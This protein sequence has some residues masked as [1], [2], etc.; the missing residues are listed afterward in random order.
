MGVPTH[1]SK[2]GQKIRKGG[3][4]LC[5]TCSLFSQKHKGIYVLILLESVIGESSFS[6]SNSR[7]KLGT[8]QQSVET[9]GGRVGSIRHPSHR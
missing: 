6:R 4:I 7:F 1:E 2:E 5:R 8:V 3:T 9:V